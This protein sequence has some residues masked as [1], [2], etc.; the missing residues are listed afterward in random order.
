MTNIDNN[1]LNIELSLTKRKLIESF[2][3]MY[4]G[5]LFPE[6]IFY[7]GIF[8]KALANIQGYLDL[9]EKKN[10]LMSSALIRIHLD[11]LLTI[12]AIN[13][14]GTN[15]TNH[16]RG[17]DGR[18]ENYKPRISYS[19]LA[20]DF[21]KEYNTEWCLSVF[22]NCSSF[23]HTSSKYFSS[24]IVNYENGIFTNRICFNGD[25]ELDEK[26]ISELLLAIIEISNYLIIYFDSYSDSKSSFVKNFTNS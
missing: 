26:Q 16:L 18:L 14:H 15:L 25:V 19:N 7:I 3:A 6:N 8:Q 21:D 2:K 24:T 23:V 1:K 13:K 9:I 20:E 11:S 17:K 5:E 22:K 4:T 12:F 10:Y